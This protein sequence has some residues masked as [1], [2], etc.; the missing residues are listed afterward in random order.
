MASEFPPFGFTITP[1]IRKRRAMLILSC[2]W[3]SHY[4]TY[5]SVSVNGHIGPVM[6]V[7]SLEAIGLMASAHICPPQVMEA[8]K[9]T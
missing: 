7:M 8:V 5:V 3:C 4:H 1:V 6:G 9:K 2:A